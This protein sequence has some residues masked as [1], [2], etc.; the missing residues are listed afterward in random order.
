MKCICDLLNRHPHFNFT[1]DLVKTIVPSM[2][3][4]A[5]EVRKN[6]QTRMKLN[7]LNKYKLNLHMNE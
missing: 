5:E 7:K 1:S 3:S 2:I 6:K 4:A